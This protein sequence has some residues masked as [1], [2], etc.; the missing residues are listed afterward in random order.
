MEAET[1]KQRQPELNYLVHPQRF[2]DAR[3]ADSR[4]VLQQL[5]AAEDAE[6]F[7]VA[8]DVAADGVERVVPTWYP[9]PHDRLE[10]PRTLPRV[11][12]LC[13]RLAAQRLHAEG[14]TE[15][16]G[17]RRLD[18]HRVAEVVRRHD[19]RVRRRDAE[20]LGAL[21]LVA[22]VLDPLERRPVR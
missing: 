2:G 9:L 11:V 17:R 7:A 1:S 15:R 3:V 22:L 12:E 20:R 8:R 21:D 10:R 4:R 16:V 5:P 13:A 19:A 18:E 6:R 14:A